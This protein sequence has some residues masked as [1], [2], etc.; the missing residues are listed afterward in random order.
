LTPCDRLRLIS[1]IRIGMEHSM[2]GVQRGRIGTALL[3][4][5]KEKYDDRVLEIAWALHNFSMACRKA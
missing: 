4:N 3:R 5:T 1:S 2:A